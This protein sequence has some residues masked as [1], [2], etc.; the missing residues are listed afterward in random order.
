MLSFVNKLDSNKHFSF[1]L[2]PPAPTETDSAEKCQFIVERPVPSICKLHLTFN[3][4]EFDGPNNDNNDDND[5]DIC[6]NGLKINGEDFCGNLTGTT[7]VVKFDPTIEELKLDFETN[8]NSENEKNSFYNVT[9]RQID[10]GSEP[11]TFAEAS[12]EVYGKTAEPKV[13]RFRSPELEE[14]CNRNIDAKEFLVQSPDYPNAYPDN[15]DCVVTVYPSSDNICSL[16]IRSIQY[17][18]FCHY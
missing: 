3:S 8:N 11:Q 14:S 2:L 15:S 12:L 7:K 4:F 5:V 13:D 10:C 6:K 18:S 9:V 16:E 17:F 1:T